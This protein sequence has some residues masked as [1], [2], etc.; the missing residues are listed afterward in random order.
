[1]LRR[2][3]HF[4]P[5]GMPLLMVSR[6][7]RLPHDLI[8]ELRG[9]VDIGPTR[10]LQQDVEFGVIQIVDIA[11]RAISPA[12]NDPSTAISCIDQLSR[13]LIR[14]IGRAPPPSRFYDPP[15]VLRV[16]LP[17]IDLDGL[18]DTAF[19]QIRHYSASDVA[20]SLRLLRAYGDIASTVRDPELRDML[21]GARKRWSRAV[22]RACRT[23]TWPGCGR[24]P[25]WSWSS[26]ADRYV[27]QP[28]RIGSLPSQPIAASRTASKM[29]RRVGVACDISMI[30]PGWP[31]L[32][33]YTNRPRGA[34][35]S[36]PTT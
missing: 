8:D 25:R 12:V 3:G 32:R 26:R 7:D 17:W 18:L 5:A 34:S 31:S 10:T 9:A 28:V 14:W 24:A 29:R 23:L 19:E 16:V 21:S 11:L 35:P 30:V 36:W 15:H 20:V 22:R 13:I 1:M 6:P 4:I 33:K 27:G 2:V